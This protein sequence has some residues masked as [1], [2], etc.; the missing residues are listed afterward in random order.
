[1]V[2]SRQKRSWQIWSGLYN[3]TVE[4]LR[5][6]TIKLT[7]ARARARAMV[8]LGLGLWLGLGIGLGL[9]LGLWL[10]LGLGLGLGSVFTFKC[11]D[12]FCRRTKFNVTVQPINEYGSEVWGL[13][14]HCK[15]MLGLPP[16]ATTTA[17]YGETGTY[18]QWLRLYYRV[19][20]YYN[21]K[22]A[23]QCSTVGV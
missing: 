10:A 8:G 17:V 20:K 2:L 3:I 1:M 12:R 15:D 14:K 5:T 4:I 7:R 9:G 18:P 11:P 19:I 16:N 22:I 13:L 23:Y 6:L 21:H